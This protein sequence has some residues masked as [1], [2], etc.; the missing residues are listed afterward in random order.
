LNRHDAGQIVFLRQLQITHHAPRG[1]VRNADVAD[2]TGTYLFIQCF[3]RFQQGHRRLFFG[4]L[5]TQFA[6][7]VGLTLRPVQLIQIQI[8]CIQTLET[9]IQRGADIFAIQHLSRADS[10]VTTTG[11]SRDFARQNNLLTVAAGFE[12][13]ANITFCQSLRLWTRRN[14]IHFGGINQIDAC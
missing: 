2:F 4:V 12:P 10:V 3:Q 6:K 11:R 5:I 13:A 7:E 9:G 8:I 14:G 1:F